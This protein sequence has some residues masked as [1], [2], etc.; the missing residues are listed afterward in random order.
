MP[1]T[2]VA[3]PGPSTF[4]VDTA[5]EGGD[6]DIGDGVCATAA[7][8]CSLRAAV[9]ESSSAPGSTVQ[10]PAGTY[11]LTEGELDI[12]ADETTIQGAAAPPG[13]AAS[14]IQADGSGRVIDIAADDV[15]IAGVVVAGGDAGP[16]DGGG[17]RVGNNRSA[18]VRDS[19]IVANTA[20]D[21]GGI[22]SR[23]TLTVER[24]TVADNTANRKGGGIR[25]AGVATI[26][27]TTI[28][29]N[30]ADQG[31]GV[32]SPGSTAITH[33]TIVQNDAVS[34]SG[35]GVARNGGTLTIRHSI[36]TGVSLPRWTVE[37]T[38][39]SRGFFRS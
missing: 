29:G 13:A 39:Y 35:G 17:I 36:E 30:T 12:T 24:S 5:V 28:T 4:V 38:K 16:G 19:T 27:N 23:G 14:T 21:G 3:Q 15:V 33:A 11:V 6:T 2:S 37:S 9:E 26:D 25:N 34:S 8:G 1:Q 7:G 20:R 22:D 32:S 18:T 10:I 31:G